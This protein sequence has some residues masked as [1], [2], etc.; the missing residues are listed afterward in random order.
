MPALQKDRLDMNFGVFYDINI[1]PSESSFPLVKWGN[2]RAVHS[3]PGTSIVN[4]FIAKGAEANAQKLWED[5]I[6]Y[7]KTAFSTCMQKA[8]LG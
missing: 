7:Y 2:M 1:L 3:L 4:Y 6:A 8:G 5:D